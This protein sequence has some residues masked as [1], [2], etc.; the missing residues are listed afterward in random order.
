MLTTRHKCQ[1][2][3]M[4]IANWNDLENEQV[5]QL[6]CDKCGCYMDVELKVGVTFRSEHETEQEKYESYKFDNRSR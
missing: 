6:D 3:E 5:Q 4:L 2:G 1:C